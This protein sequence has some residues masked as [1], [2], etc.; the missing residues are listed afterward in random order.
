MSSFS[1][2]NGALPTPTILKYELTS[3]YL[4]NTAIAQVANVAGAPSVITT[5]RDATNTNS[6]SIFLPAGLY[7]MQATCAITGGTVAT[8]VAIAQQLIVDATD[9]S[10]LAS[11][12]SFLGT[13]LNTNASAYGDSVI[14]SDNFTVK[15]DV[16]KFVT[17]KL[18]SM[19]VGADGT[20]AG[21]LIFGNIGPANAITNVTPKLTAYRMV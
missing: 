9:N 14:L 7:S 2:Q 6:L 3:L 12:R 18:L 11:G 15:L 19:F 1:Y 20:F 5:L 10:I 4:V 16:G 8:P 13:T 17:V 21:Q